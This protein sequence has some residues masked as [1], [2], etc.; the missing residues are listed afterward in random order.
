MSRLTASA[1]P[2][3]RPHR[4]R[5]HRW[6]AA[7]VLYPACVHAFAKDLGAAT[8]LLFRRLIQSRRIRDDH[9]VRDVAP[10]VDNGMSSADVHVQDSCSREL[11]E[12]SEPQL[13]GDSVS[14]LHTYVR[15]ALFHSLLSTLS[16]ALIVTDKLNI[17]VSAPRDARLDSLRRKGPAKRRHWHDSAHKTIM[18]SV[19]YCKL[20]VDCRAIQKIPGPVRT[21]TE[22]VES[23]SWEVDA[24][25]FYEE[26][27]M[28]SKTLVRL[29]DYRSSTFRSHL[30]SLPSLSSV[31]GNK[32]R[33]T[34]KPNSAIRSAPRRMSLLSLPGS[35]YE[36]LL[37][38]RVGYEGITAGNFNPHGKQQDTAHWTI[39]AAEGV[40][41]RREGIPKLD[42]SFVLDGKPA[43]FQ[44]HYLVV[45]TDAKGNTRT[46]SGGLLEKQD[47]KWKLSEWSS[48]GHSE[49]PP[50]S[51]RTPVARK[52]Y[53]LA[54]AEIPASEFAKNT[55]KMEKK[56]FE[57]KMI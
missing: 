48:H 39:D 49:Q 6:P 26:F 9:E 16:S 55:F 34:C 23:K 45:S 5:V 41:G 38:D 35:S 18:E 40:G 57:K 51:L 52:G 53:A 11:E 25:L 17:N 7:T 44:Y 10:V 31:S 2:S 1:S 56:F 50:P 8:P 14:V 12:C 21:L 24:P 33:A 3:P 4:A 46:H 32:D 19:V 42:L 28:R 30:L 54:N 36:L 43:T 37:S 22:A 47:G 15:P 13:S 20:L 27:E 29:H